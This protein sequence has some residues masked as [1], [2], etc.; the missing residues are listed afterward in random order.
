MRSLAK[1]NKPDESDQG[2]RGRSLA[3]WTD[4]ESALTF[5][6]TLDT[7]LLNFLI[8]NESFQV[9]LF[10]CIKTTHQSIEHLNK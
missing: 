9:L 2:R 1:P 8:N 10:F 3:G 6:K 7:F 4:V 5:A